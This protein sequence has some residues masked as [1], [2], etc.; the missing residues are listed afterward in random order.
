MQFWYS[1]LKKLEKQQ[2]NGPNPRSRKQL[3]KFR[4]EIN[5]LEM[6][7][8]VEQIN[9]LDAGSLREWIKLTDLWQDL[10]KRM[11]KGPKLIKFWYRTKCSKSL[12]IREKQIKTTLR[13]HLIPVRMAKMDKAGNNK[14][15]RG[16]RERGTL[17]HCWLE[18]KLVQL[19]WKTVWRFLKKLKTE[20]PYDPAIALLNVY[21][22]DTKVVIQRGTSPQCS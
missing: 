20:L 16:C 19:L 11:E 9:R 18:C 10:S 13:Y 21:P 1:H 14:C 15:W 5:E 12:A 3:T 4:A 17:L 7:G 22:K 6:K 8:T 2:K